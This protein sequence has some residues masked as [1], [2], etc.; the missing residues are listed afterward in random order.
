MNNA[1]NTKG[2]IHTGII[3]GAIYRFKQQEISRQVSLTADD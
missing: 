1:Q 2:L 3:V